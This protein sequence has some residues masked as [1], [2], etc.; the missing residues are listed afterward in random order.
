MAAGYAGG[1]ALGDGRLTGRLVLGR[2]SGIILLR[3]HRLTEVIA[4]KQGWIGS[5]KLAGRRGFVVGES[6]FQEALVTIREVNFV[7]PMLKLN[8]MKL[9]AQVY[10]LG[11]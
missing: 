6:I 4:D 11:P 9:G 5:D 1:P 8:L 10:G 3:V 7:D 2:G